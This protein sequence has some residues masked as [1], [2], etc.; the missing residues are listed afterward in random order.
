[1]GTN[2]GHWGPIADTKGP[3]NNS[4]DTT[5]NS[6]IAPVV[7]SL[8]DGPVLTDICKNV[9]EMM[10]SDIRILPFIF[11]ALNGDP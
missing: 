6:L 7:E 11:R 8:L 10:D 1:M 9:D 5:D 2:C 4:L 3:K